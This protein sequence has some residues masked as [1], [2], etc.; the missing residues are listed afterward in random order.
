MRTVL[1]GCGSLGSM[2][3][4]WLCNNGHQVSVV[5]RDAASKQH[6]G[7]DFTG[8]FVTGHGIDVDVLEKAG[9]A[10]ADAVAA[11]TGIDELNLAV[12]MV[13]KRRYRVPAVVARVFDPGKIES[14]RHAGIHV[15]C[16]PA[17][18]FRDIA[19]TLTRPAVNQVLTLGHGEM[20]VVS[21]VIGPAGKGVA[22]RDVTALPDLIVIGIERQGEAF[23]PT[24]ATTFLDGDVVYFR[25]P[26]GQKTTFDRLVA[27][28]EG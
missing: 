26:E 22:V 21:V 6:L 24:G 17:W 25:V 19:D 23:A 16:P 27:G 8:E 15:V 13:A 1:V 14:F 10:K 5:D 20:Q 18:G 3:A 4:I 28:L 12:A 2:L 7:R 9:I 11:V